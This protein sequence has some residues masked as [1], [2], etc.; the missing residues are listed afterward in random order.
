MSAPRGGSSAAV[1]GGWI[2]AARS[3]KL[4]AQ[5]PLDADLTTPDGW[6]VGGSGAVVGCAWVGEV[7]IWEDPRETVVAAGE[8]LDGWDCLD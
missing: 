5:E 3:D 8:G 4:G 6:M 2:G 7:G 1:L